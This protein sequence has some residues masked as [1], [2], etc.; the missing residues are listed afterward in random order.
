MLCRTLPG[1]LFFY[2]F[3]L[4][5]FVK[6]D[7]QTSRGTP[8]PTRLCRAE[9]RR[10]GRCREKCASSAVQA[11]SL[12]VKGR[13]ARAPPEDRACLKPNHFYPLTSKGVPQCNAFKFI[14]DCRL[15]RAKSNLST[16]ASPPSNLKVTFSRGPNIAGIV[17]WTNPSDGLFEGVQIRVYDNED[18]GSQMRMCL[19][20]TYSNISNNNQVTSCK[21]D[22]S[23]MVWKSDG[24]YTL[25]MNSMPSPSNCYQ[26]PN[27][28]EIILSPACDAA[29]KHVDPTTCFSPGTTAI[30][31]TQGM[32]TTQ[33]MKTTEGRKTTQETSQT[34]TSTS[35]L[36]FSNISTRATPHAEDTQW[37]LTKQQFVTWSNDTSDAT[38]STTATNYQT[39]SCNAAGGQNHLNRSTNR[40]CA[41]AIS[42]SGNASFPRDSS[43]DY[44][45]VQNICSSQAAVEIHHKIGEFSCDLFT[46][47]NVPRVLLVY[48]TSNDNNARECRSICK[49][50][51]TDYGINV[52]SHEFDEDEAR[53]NIPNWAD[54]HTKRADFI[55]FVC[56]R[57]LKADFDCR[58]GRGFGDSQLLRNLCHFIEGMYTN[59]RAMAE[60]KCI[61]VLLKQE[62]ADFV[63]AIMETSA[64]YCWKTQK[65][66]IIRLLTAKE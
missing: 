23:L 28:S 1:L 27:V 41:V 47:N 5:S 3:L 22:K 2:L 32:T 24:S 49:M 39:E 56:T 8:C 48:S 12:T 25:T 20:I 59:S 18:G 29:T 35:Y 36:V 45:K 61:P 64:I 65:E 54:Q 9:E 14:P 55:V 38:T 33:G 60:A 62:D 46:S 42:S 57:E 13:V 17:S 43:S 63:P 52:T 51:R 44:N 34:V 53:K 31:S 16:L 19:E 50:L 26:K 15:K 21:L 66:Q 4:T 40:N 10:H 58:D 37:R 6:T 30:T 7:K 11:D